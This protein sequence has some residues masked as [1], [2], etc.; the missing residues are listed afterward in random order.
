MKVKVKVNLRFSMPSAGGRGS[1]R[2]L[3]ELATSCRDAK[4]MGLHLGS[5]SV[6]W[7]VLTAESEVY[8]TVAQPSQ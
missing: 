8:S 3:I 1:I 7:T 5:K 2:D 4:L 6:H